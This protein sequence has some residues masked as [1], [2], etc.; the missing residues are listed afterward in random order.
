MQA[1][2]ESREKTGLEF[3]VALLHDAQRL[4]WKAI[5]LVAA[6]VKPGMTEKDAK[7]ILKRVLKDLGATK[8]WHPP[9]IRF[10]KNTALPFGKPSAPDVT[11]KENDIYFLDIGPVFFG[12]EGDA[13][14]TIAV[15]QDPEMIRLSQDAIEVFNQTKAHWLKTGKTGIELYEFA[16]R[17]ADSLGWR[18]S[19]EGAS[20]HRVSDFPHAVHFRG[21]LKKFELKPTE[22]RWI[23]EIHLLHKEKSL[24]AFFEDLL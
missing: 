19:S 16:E 12:H 21:G 10:G 8:S 11:L 3:N 4:T 18:L 22:N 20:G 7:E 24:G 15:G 14:K 13:G 5:D 9:Q 1:S 6:E 23:L 2:N 17:T